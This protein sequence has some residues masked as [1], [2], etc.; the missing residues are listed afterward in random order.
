[1]QYWDKNHLFAEELGR[2]LESDPGHPRPDCCT[3]HAVH[4]DEVAV[5]RQDAHWDIQLPSAVF[6][7]GPVVYAPDFS[8]VVTD[9]LSR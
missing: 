9:L 7:N 4:W 3:R 8:R 6:L 1:V 2:R 5:Y